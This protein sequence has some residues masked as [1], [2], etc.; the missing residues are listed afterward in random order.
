MRITIG[1]ILI[2]AMDQIKEDVL[3]EQATIEDVKGSLT[4]LGALDVIILVNEE[5]TDVRILKRRAG[6]SYK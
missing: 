6:P 2:I 4:E 1:G 3:Y 5:N